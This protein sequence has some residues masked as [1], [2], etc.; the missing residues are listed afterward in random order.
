MTKAYDAARL[1][2]LIEARGRAGSFVAAT[3]H[4]PILPPP[5][6]DTGMNMPPEIPGGLLSRAI[7]ETSA[8]LLAGSEMAWLQYA[9]AGGA[10]QDRAAGAA[11]LSA[12]GLPSV[13]EQVIVTAGG[14]NAPHAILTSTL[15]AGDAHRLWA[16]RLSRV[17][18]ACRAARVAI[19]AAG[20]AGCR[21]ARRG[22]PRRTSARTI[23]RADQ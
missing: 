19:V 11:L 15:D 2:G 20:H 21:R 4:M 18:G 16:L 7:V 13:E 12:R 23:C 1:R 8:A 5:S 14:Q 17:E 3:P 10:P 9:P 6:V 22:V